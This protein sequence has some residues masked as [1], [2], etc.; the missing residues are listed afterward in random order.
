MRREIKETPTLTME[1]LVCRKAV[2]GGQ[3]LR[4]SGELLASILGQ[5]NSFCTSLLTLLHLFYSSFY[6][7]LVT[8]L[9]TILI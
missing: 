2:E 8:S 4:V 1:L 3:T 9:C 5:W 6:Y 7:Q